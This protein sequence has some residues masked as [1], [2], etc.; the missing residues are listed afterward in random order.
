[1]KKER[2]KKI[3]RAGTVFILTNLGLAILNVI[4]GILSGS[5]A[6]ISDA[7][8][9]L[10]DTISG[11]V[12]VIGEKIAGMKKYAKKRE[13]IERWTA[14]IIA[15]VIIGT[16]GHIL[17]EAI[18]KIIEPE[19][20]EYSLTVMILLAVSIVVKWALAFY[21]KKVGREI[22]SDAVIAS[23]V[24]SMND[25]LISI[26]VFLSAV[27]YL[28][29]KVDIEAYIS[30]LI[31][32]IIAKIGLELIWPKDFGHHHIHSGIPHEHEE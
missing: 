9:S 8:H 26:A 2:S 23:G 18:E 21:L 10:I 32:L 24:E 11:F 31:S 27:I 20:V 30:I 5:L 12:V 1:M 28:V 25:M 15:I 13:K 7:T 16:A 6:I 3:T 22:K 19:E 4:I 14:I 17:A 29:F